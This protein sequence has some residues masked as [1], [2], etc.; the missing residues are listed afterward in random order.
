MNNVKEFKIELKALLNKYNASIEFDCSSDSD[1]YGI[2]DGHIGIEIDG[3]KF[4]YKH[5]N[6]WAITASD[7]DDYVEDK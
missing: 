1:T 2:Y 7:V 3:K 5:Q 4:R 6:Y